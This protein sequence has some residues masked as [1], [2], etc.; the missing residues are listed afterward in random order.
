M[1]IALFTYS[2]QPRGSVIHTHELAEGLQ[3]LGHPVCV[4]ALDKEGKGMGRTLSYQF[5][6]VPA[7]PVTGAIDVLIQQRIQ[8]FAE[9]LSTELPLQPYDIFHA[10]DCISANTL[11]A[12]RQRQIIP[13]FLRTVHH[14]EDYN[15]DYLRQCQDR[16]IREPDRCFCVSAYW[17]QQLRQQYSI[18][19][20]R[21]T[22]GVNRDRFTPTSSSRD[23]DL[24]QQMGIL[25]SP[26]FLTVGGIEPRKNTIHLLRAF[27]TVLHHH[28]HAQLV[29]AGGSTLFDYQ[30]YRDEFFTVV[31]QMRIEIGRS[32]L[33]P[34]VIP[35]VDLPSLYRSADAFVFPSVKEGWG[36]V[37]LEALASGLPAIVSDQAPFTE[38]LTHQ[39]ARFVEPHDPDAIAQAMLAIV[40]PD[41]A[42]TIV[43][44]SESVVQT[45][46]WTAS[47]QLHLNHYQELG[48]LYAGN[49]L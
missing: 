32:L 39:Q 44:N 14:I 41:I 33:L 11:A 38:F 34:G 47:A 36:L 12:L 1:R 20:S 8:E 31:K 46:S 18:H 42:R 27:A 6:S 48:A 22:N 49:S 25:G 15:S 3:Q 28:P 45:Y 29:I 37:V 5:Q 43:Q 30:A 13:H 21:V 2:T 40:Q 19:A 24:Q 16:S 10:Q 35:D 17:Q 4:Y 26:I 7:F 23:A 9:F